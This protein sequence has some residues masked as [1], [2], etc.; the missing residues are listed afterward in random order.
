VKTIGRLLVTVFVAVLIIYF[1]VKV[2]LHDRPVSVDASKP[3]VVYDAPLT[4]TAT[5][6]RDVIFGF[7][8]GKRRGEHYDCKFYSS[9]SH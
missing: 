8:W 7:T 9:K 2:L 4:P 3:G 6:A 1:A 5:L